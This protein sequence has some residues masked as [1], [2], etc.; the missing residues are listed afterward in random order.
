MLGNGIVQ[1]SSPG[2]ADDRLAVV[3][4]DLDL[5][6]QPARLQ[7]SAPDGAD[8]IPE[9]EARNDVRATADATQSNIGLH[10]AIHVV[11]AVRGERASRRQDRLE[12]GEVVRLARAAALLSPPARAI[13]RSSQTR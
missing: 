8:G 3:V 13:W 2:S 5:H 1:T 11:E 6:P 4:E 10:V 9:G 12:R 7:L